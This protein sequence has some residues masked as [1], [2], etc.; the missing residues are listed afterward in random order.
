MG[1]GD[2]GVHHYFHATCLQQWIRSCRGGREATCPICR[3]RV[4]FNGQRLGDFLQSPAAAT[5]DSE[6]RTFLESI[7]DGLRHKN[8]W[9]DM[10][11]TEKVG[12]SVGI[13]AAAGWGFMLGYN[14][15]GNR[16]GASVAIA[17]DRLVTRNLPREHQI[18]Q[19]VG[20][21]AGLIARIVKT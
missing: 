3:G 11:T 18:A 1:N 14:E 2:G 8:T 13:V 12:F 20:W 10:S 5:L 16:G 4:Q 21:V 15:T 19:G 17:N 9:T 6:E 7:A